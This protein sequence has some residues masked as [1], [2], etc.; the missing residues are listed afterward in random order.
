VTSTPAKA[1]PESTAPPDFERSLAELEAIVDKLEQGELSLDESLQQFERGVQLTRVCQTAL[2]Q[3]EHKVELLLRKS[4][5]REL[6]ADGE[7]ADEFEA[8]R[9]EPDDADR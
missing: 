2:K 6:S 7:Q 3:A 1:A 9:F 5:A 4:G 8:T